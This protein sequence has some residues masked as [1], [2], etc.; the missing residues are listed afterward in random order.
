Y[1]VHDNKNKL[2]HCVNIQVQIPNKYKL[3]KTIRHTRHLYKPQ[4]IITHLPIINDKRQDSNIV[5][6]VNRDSDSRVMSHME[7]SE[8]YLNKEDSDILCKVNQDEI[9]STITLG[10]KFSLSEHCA[11]F[12]IFRNIFQFP[13]SSSN[14][15]RRA[16][17]SLCLVPKIL[18]KVVQ[19]NS[20]FRFSIF[21][22][23]MYCETRFF[24]KLH[25]MEI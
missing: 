12:E 4:N 21:L 7:G 6:K 20:S 16:L 22:W 23:I 10:N 8:R 5:L 24:R 9:I 19:V 2:T 3:I 13:S 11:N 17:C 1:P 14:S 18:G 15:S 25:I